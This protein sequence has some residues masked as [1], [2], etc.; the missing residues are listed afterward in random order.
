MNAQV[1]A[2]GQARVELIPEF[3]RLA[4]HVPA[5]FK[6]ARRE[7]ALLGARRLLV[8]TDAGDQAVK[9]M[10]GERELQAFGFSR[11]R[12]RGWRQVASIA[13]IDGQYSTSNS[14]SHSTA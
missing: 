12:A 13:S 4:A 14:R 10:L 11:G 1:R 6:A 5:A 8:A 9:P 7:Y 2:G 3:E